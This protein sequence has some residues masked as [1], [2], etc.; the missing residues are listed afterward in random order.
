[1]AKCQRTRWIWTH[2]YAGGDFIR[3]GWIYNKQS[4]DPE[5]KIRLQIHG[6]NIDLDCNIRI[7]E[8]ASVIAGLGKVLA[9][10]TIAGHFKLAR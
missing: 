1:M 8:A 5:D 9:V 10:Q 4:G 2:L 3:A 7:D 6:S